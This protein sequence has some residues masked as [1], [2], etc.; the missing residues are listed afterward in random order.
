MTFTKKSIF[1]NPF[2]FLLLL[3]LLLFFNHL[4][5]QESMGINFQAIARDKSKNPAN[6]R[7]I[8]ILPLYNNYKMVRQYDGRIDLDEDIFQA[9]FSRVKK[10]HHIVFNTTKP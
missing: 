10:K 7:K 4:F 5:S 3:I 8:Y 1:N 6:N 2:R 9:V